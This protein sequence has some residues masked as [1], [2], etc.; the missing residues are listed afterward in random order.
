MSLSEQVDHLLTLSLVP[1]GQ[2]VRVLDVRADQKTSHRLSEL[3]IVRGATLRI[4]QDDGGTLLVAVGDTRLGL[5]HGLAHRVQ[6]V[7]TEEEQA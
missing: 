1:P 7:I 5:A 3:G 4:V 2:R 6:V